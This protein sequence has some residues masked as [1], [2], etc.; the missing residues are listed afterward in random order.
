MSIATPPPLPQHQSGIPI[1]LYA[2]A[3]RRLQPHMDG[4]VAPAGFASAED[5]RDALRY[6]S[7]GR[8]ERRE[9]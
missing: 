3:R 6:Y 9:P 4:L 5:L 8:F 7:R 2:P 1:S